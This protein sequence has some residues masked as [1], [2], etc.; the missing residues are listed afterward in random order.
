MKRKNKQEKEEKKEGVKEKNKGRSKKRSLERG[1]KQRTCTELLRRIGYLPSWRRR[2]R[3]RRRSQTT[4]LH[5][6]LLLFNLLASSN[7]LPAGK[8]RT[9]VCWKEHFNFLKERKVTS[10]VLVYLVS[11]LTSGKT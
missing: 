2:R 1:M 10:L 9:Y 3:R 5:V 8:V 4:D 7:T 6:C 11:H